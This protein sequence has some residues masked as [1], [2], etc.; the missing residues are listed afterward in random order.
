MRAGA[1]TP[2]VRFIQQHQDRQAG[3]H[4][5]NTPGPSGTNVG[6]GAFLTDVT[7]NTNTFNSS[8]AV[9]ATPQITSSQSNNVKKRPP[10]ATP[11]P[12]PSVA[13]NKK[14]AFV[15]ASSAASN[16]SSSAGSSTIAA[17]N[18]RSK[19]LLAMQNREA[20]AGL[21]QGTKSLD[22]L[23]AKGRKVFVRCA[24]DISIQPWPL[25][26][27]I[28][29]IAA[30][31][32]DMDMMQKHGLLDPNTELHP[33]FSLEHMKRLYEAQC[34]DSLRPATDERLARFCETLGNFACGEQF[35]MRECKFEAHSIQAICDIFDEAGAPSSI[36]HLDLSGNNL[37]ADG[38]RLLA[39]ALPKLTEL[40][41][42]RL[43]S[44]NLGDGIG[45][46]AAALRDN[47]SVTH[48]DLSATHCGS[49]RNSILGD[50]VRLMCT[51]LRRNRVL[52]HI[53]LSNTSLK[54]NGPILMES[55]SLC[56]SLVHIGLRDNGLDH[57]CAAPLAKMVTQLRVLETLDL[58]ENKFTGA[59]IELLCRALCTRKLDRRADTVLKTLDLSK[60]KI[61]AAADSAV[62][63]LCDMIETLGVRRLVLSDNNLC[64]AGYDPLEGTRLPPT[65]AFVS[66]IFRSA[67]R[68]SSG[69]EWLEMANCGFADLPSVIVDL[70]AAPSTLTRLDLSRNNLRDVGAVVLGEGLANP[71]SNLIQLDITQNNITTEGAKHIAAGL[72]TNRSLRHLK[73]SNGARMDEEKSGLVDA[74]MGHK[75]LETVDL[76]KACMHDLRATLDRNRKQ[77]SVDSLPQ[78][79][80]TREKINYFSRETGDVKDQAKE[81]RHRL[82]HQL[83]VLKIMRERAKSS[84]DGQ[85]ETVNSMT[86]EAVEWRAHYDEMLTRHKE[87]H[88]EILSKQQKLNRQLDE[89]TRRA[90]KEATEK[91]SLLTDLWLM[92]TEFEIRNWT[93]CK[94]DPPCLPSPGQV[95][96][97]I[98]EMHKKEKP[99]DEE[100]ALE[101]ELE[102]M[103]GVIRD[104][105]ETCAMYHNKLLDLGVHDDDIQ[106]VFPDDH[107]DNFRRMRADRAKEQVAAKEKLQQM[108]QARSIA[109]E[110]ADAKKK[111]TDEATKRGKAGP[112]TTTA[113]NRKPAAKSAK[114]NPRRKSSS[115][116]VKIGGSG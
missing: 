100:V 39:R 96:G 95:K 92:F 85:K 13:N 111:A 114:G 58:A 11:S 33:L 53:N 80:E 79:Q 56:R 34:A 37:G 62:Q 6:D 61:D 87:L 32:G 81:E 31:T 107:P 83:D 4:R 76:Q 98:E 115:K 99:V 108:Q 110:A 29:N 41:V 116:P 28:A 7:I 48:F 77:R 14:P 64:L 12:S 1:S 17:N 10:I 36:S 73:C 45:A 89:A 106:D 18:I 75:K 65:T 9:G 78:A 8:T 88:E 72:R 67:S 30:I 93:R 94:I 74:I 104:Q 54:T 70:M 101:K 20:A 97:R 84:S 27:A 15:S 23:S 57:E 42:L 22:K 109:E 5:A 46:I 112:D 71:E 50:T 2:T 66:K 86:N 60:N 3:L 82:E 102:R 43:G 16:S 25:K 90:D 26:P 49:H 68:L 59:S 38:G 63:A 52:A 91:N 24:D 44:A 55:M 35:V 69:V 113:N 40:C 47:Q 105:K 21:V 51:M 103:L 19:M